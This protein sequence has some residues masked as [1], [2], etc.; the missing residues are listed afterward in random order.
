[1]HENIIIVMMIIV[2]TIVTTIIGKDHYEEG[3]LHYDHADHDHDNY[4]QTDIL[5]TIALIIA[6]RQLPSLWTFLVAKNQEKTIII[7]LQ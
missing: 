3:S 5:L 2:T 6:C 4:L 7:I 1:M